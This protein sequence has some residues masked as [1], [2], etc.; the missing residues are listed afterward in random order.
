MSID[1]RIELDADASVDYQDGQ[2]I[3]DTADTRTVYGPSAVVNIRKEL[4]MVAGK[5]A[6]VQA[7]K[8]VDGTWMVWLDPIGHVNI[9]EEQAAQLGAEFRHLTVVQS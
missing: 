3:V 2:L 4:G 6:T 9:T 7:H 8:L 5:P 1:I